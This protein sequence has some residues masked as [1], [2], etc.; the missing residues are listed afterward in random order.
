[1]PRV[2]GKKGYRL[3]ETGHSF[4]E[5]GVE[6]KSRKNGKKKTGGDS[7][8]ELSPLVKRE[9]ETKKGK[10]R[11]GKVRK[12]ARGKSTTTLSHFPKKGGGSHKG[13]KK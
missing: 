10:G 1:L 6:R 3:A 8:D 2:K 11:G 7:T 4:W 12:L 5:E 13:K 9:S